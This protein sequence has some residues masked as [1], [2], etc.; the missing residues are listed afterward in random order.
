M[1]E[2][3]RRQAENELYFRSLNERIEQVAEET[4]EESPGAHVHD[5]VCEC[6]NRE[7]A[8]R[9]A[10]TTSEYERIRAV[11]TQFLVAPAQEH[12]DGGLEAVVDRSS[13]YWIVQKLGDAAE[14]AETEDPRDHG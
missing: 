8:E 10:L 7:C 3:R 9:V 2:S 5:F 4:F 1:D 13:R 12:V 6:Q 14:L 11:S